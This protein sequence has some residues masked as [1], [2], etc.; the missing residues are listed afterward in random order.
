M[1]FGTTGLTGSGEASLVVAGSTVEAEAA[2]LFA[3]SLLLF[4]T[5]LILA[6]GGP[7][8]VKPGSKEPREGRT[9]LW[10]AICFEVDGVGVGGTAELVVLGD[11][12]T[13]ARWTGA[14]C[15]GGRA[16]LYA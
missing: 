8:D 11:S 14:L 2:S 9:E 16:V 7:S 12:G 5:D 13:E 4:L 6:G 1:V 15:S 10:P 3:S